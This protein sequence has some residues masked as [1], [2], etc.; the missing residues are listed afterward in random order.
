MLPQMPA[1]PRRGGAAGVFR[2]PR[3]AV[4]HRSVDEGTDPAL[5]D[6]SHPP[7]VLAPVGLDYGPGIYVVQQGHSRLAQVG[8]FCRPVVHLHVDIRDDGTVPG[9]R[10][11]VAPDALQV[12]GHGTVA[13]GSNGQVTPVGED[14]HLQ[15]LALALRSHLRPRHQLIR[16]ALCPGPLQREVHAA[17]QSSIVL[18][19][20]L[21]QGLPVAPGCRQRPLLRPVCS[22]CRQGHVA[23]RG[24]GIVCLGCQHDGQFRGIRHHQSLLRAAYACA[25]VGPKLH[26]GGRTQRRQPGL[27]RGLH[28]VVAD[29]FIVCTFQ[30]DEQVHGPCLRGHLMNHQTPRR[31]AAQVLPAEA[32]APGI[33]PLCLRRGRGEV[34]RKVVV[35]GRRGSLVLDVQ[36][37]QVLVVA[38][39]G[40][41]AVPERLL[42]QL[43][44]LAL[45]T[46]SHHGSQVAV[47]QWQVVLHPRILHPVALGGLEVPQRLRIPRPVAGAAAHILRR[48]SHSAAA[49]AA[50]QS[51]QDEHTLDEIYFRI[52]VQ[53]LAHNVI[54][55]FSIDR[56]LRQRYGF[57]PAPQS[58]PW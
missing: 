42:V 9:G 1:Q 31:P 30:A 57:I 12:A 10:V 51:K 34:Q 23:H 20:F 46:T 26:D 38:V 6:A 7:R 49:E 50:A 27:H 53:C 40:G 45:H 25:A 15:R 17:E 28:A 32:D 58:F 33:P 29:L 54:S 5:R 24:G 18:L 43:H 39:D 13:R 3:V 52:M 37:P 16:G 19:M 2:V 22:R 44:P 36:V 21:A 56:I 35:R 14:Q 48:L 41:A 47:A 11:R 55:L 8:G 4:S